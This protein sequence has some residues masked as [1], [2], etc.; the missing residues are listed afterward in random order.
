[1]PWWTTKDE[2]LNWLAINHAQLPEAQPEE[3]RREDPLR[4][5]QKQLMDRIGCHSVTFGQALSGLQRLE[6]A[7]RLFDLQLPLSRLVNW[8]GIELHIAPVGQLER[9]LDEFQVVLPHDTTL[10]ELW[11]FEASLRAERI[12]KAKKLKKSTWHSRRKRTHFK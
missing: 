9:N 2:L 5:L 3:S 11:E 8:S 7:E 10:D 4:R 12:Q 1:M 6:A